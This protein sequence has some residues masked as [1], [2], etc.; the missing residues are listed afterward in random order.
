MGGRSAGLA[1]PREGRCAFTLLELVLVLVIIATVM[2][3]AAP[4]LRG[5]WRGADAR[6]AATQLLSVIQWGRIK[7]VS[8]STIYRLNIDARDGRYWL[9]MQDGGEFVDV[10]SDFGQTFTLPAQMRIELRDATTTDSI[11]FH[12]NGRSEVATIHLLGPDDG[13]E[14]RIA[15]PSPAEPFRLL[16]PGEVIP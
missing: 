13:E 3:L 14:R 12:P 4:S 6:D 10:G 11:E 16:S 5:F 1:A 15:C 7:A 9:T 2:A 8:D